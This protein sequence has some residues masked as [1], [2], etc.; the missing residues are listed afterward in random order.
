M[1][2]KQT[3]TK[4]ETMTQPHPTPTKP[5]KHRRIRRRRRGKVLFCTAMVLACLLWCAMG[6]VTLFDLTFNGVPQ[7][8]SA[9]PLLATFM[10]GAL[11]TNS[12]TYIIIVRTLLRS[13]KQPELYS[14]RKAAV[15]LVVALLYGLS[16]LPGERILGLTTLYLLNAGPFDTTIYVGNC[17][18]ALAFMAIMVSPALLLGRLFREIFR[19][20]PTPRVQR[21]KPLSKRIPRR[22]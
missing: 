13:I 3:V 15:M 6:L 2:Y 11:L 4:R 21:F 17:L 20:P 7:F 19:R 1:S 16:A 9:R 12:I 5:R 22:A 10:V 14:G 18:F 8:V